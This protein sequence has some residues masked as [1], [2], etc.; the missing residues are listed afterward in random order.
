M[1]VRL[2]LVLAL[3]L[4]G[5]R[6]PADRPRKPVQ[7]KVVDRCD[8]QREPDPSEVVLM[9][10]ETYVERDG[11]RLKFDFARPKR[12]G[13]FP[14]V[15]LIHGGAWISGARGDMRTEMMMLTAEGYAAASVDYRLSHSGRDIFPSAIRDVRCALQVLRA[16]SSQL[17]IDPDR[18]AAVGT[19]SGGH[20]A[21]LLATASDESWFESRCPAHDLPG[22]LDGAVALYAPLDL[23]ITQHSVQESIITGFLGTTPDRDPR[24]ADLASPIYH[25]DED[26]PP[27]LLVHG[28]ADEAV[29]V[30]QSRQMWKKM[31]KLGVSGAY[32]EIPEVGHG[33]FMF[34]G[35]QEFQRARCTTV[36]FLRQILGPR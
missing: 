27:L 25:L 26:D 29:P 6:C 10:G 20:L 34:K 21:A 3:L 2:L 31:K 22:H 7:V 32:I 12:G 23:R 17:N 19:S 8:H 33:F 5:C 9:T 35:Q 1:V 4:G 36:G 11:N 14:L 30:G 28:A 18:V 16:W 13:P 15:M 24:R